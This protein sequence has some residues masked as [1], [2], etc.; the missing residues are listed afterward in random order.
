MF[1]ICFQAVNAKTIIQKPT[2]I[3]YDESM[4][5]H[6]CLWDENHQERPERFTRVLER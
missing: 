2:G 6:R 5:Q 3:V 4:A 1:L